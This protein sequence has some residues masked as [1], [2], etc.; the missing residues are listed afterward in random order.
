MSRSDNLLVLYHARAVLQ[1]RW[2]VMALVPPKPCQ[3]ERCPREEEGRNAIWC[4]QMARYYAS[5]EVRD[6]LRSI[7]GVRTTIQALQIWCKACKDDR[8]VAWA[9]A[10]EAWWTELDQ[11][12]GI[13]GPEAQA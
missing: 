10:R 1:E 12:F 11:L 9:A 8:V 13:A 5:T 2:R 7:A 3:D 6:P 4:G